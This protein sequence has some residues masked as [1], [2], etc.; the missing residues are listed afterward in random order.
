MPVIQT[1]RRTTPN[2]EAYVR[3]LVKEWQGGALAQGPIILVDEI[4]QTKSLHVVVIWDR[5]ADVPDYE[6]SAIILDAYEKTTNPPGMKVTIA[7]G[8]TRSEAM[9]LGFMPYR[10]GTVRQES[11][12][13]SL[14]QLRRAMAKEGAIQTHDGLELAFPSEKLAKE[15]YER[16]NSRYPGVWTL[17]KR[18]S[19]E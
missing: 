2:R 16:L 4:G 12:P 1:S 5:W 9:S 10:I 7:M 19:V 3:S 13:Y 11:D 14:E 8:L 6:R 18:E 17:Y 15:A